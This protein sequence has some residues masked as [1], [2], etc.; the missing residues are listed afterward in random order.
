MQR[1]A[2]PRRGVARW[3]EFISGIRVLTANEVS[4]PRREMPMS[5]LI[6]I[7]ENVDETGACSRKE[8]I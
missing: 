8:F 3:S 7:A 2:D 6:S 5:L 4:E 1:Q